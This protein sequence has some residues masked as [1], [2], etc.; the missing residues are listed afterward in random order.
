M[1]LDLYTNHNIS[2]IFL[3]NHYWFAFVL[4]HVW[5]KLHHFLWCSHPSATPTNYSFPWKPVISAEF[6]DWSVARVWDKEVASLGGGL[7]CLEQQSPPPGTQPIPDLQFGWILL[8]STILNLSFSRA[9]ILQQ[10]LRS[11]LSLPVKWVACKFRFADFNLL[12]VLILDLPSL[13]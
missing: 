7:R 2:E 9:T 6:Y 10:L 1:I 8:L 12:W 5:V 13:D 4:W 11:T 3:G